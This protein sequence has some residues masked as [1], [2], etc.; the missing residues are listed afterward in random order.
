[1]ATPVSTFLRSVTDFIVRF[2][3]MSK[4]M[5]QVLAEQNARFAPL[6]DDEDPGSHP[7]RPPAPDGS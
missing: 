7:P 1:M 4:S 6:P 5:E 3:P 2:W